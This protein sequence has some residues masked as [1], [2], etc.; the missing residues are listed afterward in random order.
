MKK[1]SILAKLL[2]FSI[3]MTVVTFLLIYGVFFMA[4]NQYNDYVLN[5]ADR[6]FMERYRKELRSTTENAATLL[7]TIYSMNNLN[8]NEKIRLSRKLIRNMKF[9]SDGYFFVYESGTGKNLIHGATKNLEGKNLWDLQGPDKKYIIR[10]LDRTANEQKIFHSY[11]WSKPGIKGEYPKLGTA[12][13]VPGSNMWVGTGAYI[14][15]IEIEKNELHEDLNSIIFNTNIKIV[16][17]FMVIAVFAIIIIILMA[18]SLVNPIKNMIVSSQ[19]ITNGNYDVTIIA[20]THDEIGQLAETFN[21]MALKLK[22]Y[23]ENLE[24]K[25]E[26]R[27]HELQEAMELLNKSNGILEGLS[28]K[29]SKYLS[30]QIRESIFSGKQDVVIEARRKKLTV[31]FSDIRNFTATTDRLET[32]ELTDLL[33]N[34]LEEMSQI[35]LKHGATIDKFIGDAIM[36]FFGDP[37]SRGEKEDAVACVSMALE[38]RER[39]HELQKIWLDRGVSEP[40]HIRMGINTGYC[41]V[42]NFGS[43][44]RMDY[45][46]IGSQ[47]NLA[48]RLESSAEPDQILISHET[49]SQIKESIYCMKKEEIKVKGIHYDVQTYQVIDFM[50]KIDRSQTHIEEHVEGFSISADLSLISQSEKTIILNKLK[51]AFNKVKGIK[52]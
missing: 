52:G 13:L 31:F 22:D 11:F 2:I 10:D 6:L 21:N 38:M 14:D 35:A 41:T 3:S 50:D 15:N 42:G 7:R 16:A 39:I 24:M 49:Y 18:R 8:E 26:D 40:F 48:S 12:M 28:Q 51:D 23:T 20:K 4:F 44:E 43:N 46:I 32:E 27:T 9:G 1:I 29:L 37:E 17:S 25:V 33:N 45:T 47:V 36:L 30:P 34:Y 5:Q 19:E